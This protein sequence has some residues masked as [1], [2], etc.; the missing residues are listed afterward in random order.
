ME[1][2]NKGRKLVWM[3]EGEG[4]VSRDRDLIGL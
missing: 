3:L 4:V 1:F 2:R